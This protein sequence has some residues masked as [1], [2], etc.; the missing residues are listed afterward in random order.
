M[1]NRDAK[2]KEFLGKFSVLRNY[3]EGSSDKF[4]KQVDEFSRFMKAEQLVYLDEEY[5][6]R[7][8]RFCTNL[9]DVWISE[10]LR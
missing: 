4:T 1:C 2:T 6:G 8:K 3:T 10:F 7:M 9:I 5:K